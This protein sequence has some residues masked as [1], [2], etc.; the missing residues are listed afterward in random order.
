MRELTVYHR[1]VSSTF[2]KSGQLSA[3]HEVTCRKGHEETTSGERRVKRG[4]EREE[5]ERE[6]E[7]G[8]RV[9]EELGR[10]DGIIVT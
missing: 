7:G 1:R 8:E 6:G 4:G 3:N 9:A 10:R 5:G 2:Y